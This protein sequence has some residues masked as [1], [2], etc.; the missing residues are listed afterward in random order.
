MQEILVVITVV[1]S[2]SIIINSDGTKMILE[3]VP[4][5][6]LCSSLAWLITI[7]A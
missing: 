5:A 6:A 4:N 7:C 2:I 3:V 1:V